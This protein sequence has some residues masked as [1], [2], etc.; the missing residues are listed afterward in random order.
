MDKDLLIE[1]ITII[2][3]IGLII[4]YVCVWRPR[5]IRKEKKDILDCLVTLKKYWLAENHDMVESTLILCGIRFTRYLSQSF[6][7]IHIEACDD[8]ADA[9]AEYNR[10]CFC[11]PYPS[12]SID[13]NGIEFDIPIPQREDMTQKE[14]QKKIIQSL[15][16]MLL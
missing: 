11:Y 4:V 3:I 15:Q 6:R 1:I 2:V 14:L 12:T 16:K 13:C 5:R 7:D 10:P 8:I 9:L